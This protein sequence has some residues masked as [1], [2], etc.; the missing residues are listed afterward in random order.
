M[1]DP[2]AFEDSTSIMEDRVTVDTPVPGRRESPWWG[3]WLPKHSK[4]QARTTGYF[5]LSALPPSAYPLAFTVEARLMDRPGVLSSVVQAIAAE[6]VNISLINCYPTAEGQAALTAVCVHEALRREL[7]GGADPT[8]TWYADS[9]KLEIAKKGLDGS[10]ERIRDIIVQYQPPQ[11]ATDSVLKSQ[12]AVLAAA[13]RHERCDLEWMAPII[14]PVT[15]FRSAATQCKPDEVLQFQVSSDGREFIADDPPA[16]REQFVSHGYEVPSRSSCLHSPSYLYLKVG[17]EGFSRMR[18]EIDKSLACVQ[19]ST[20]CA[21][22]DRI[23]LFSNDNSDGVAA[24]VVIEFKSYSELQTAF[25][26]AERSPRIPTG[27]VGGPRLSISE[28]NLTDLVAR[29]IAKYNKF[30][31]VVSD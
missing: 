31:L 13:V 15:T 29:G 12:S 11:F 17:V 25:E 16:L 27:I 30:P 23:P 22:S 2:Q 28:S 24:T 14:R 1:A 7:G 5:L 6:G 20:P 4:D 3:A 21:S 10:I 9:E 18:A 19:T 26:L 8:S